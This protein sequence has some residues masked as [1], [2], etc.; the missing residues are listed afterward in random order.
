MKAKWFLLFFVLSIGAVHGQ[1]NRLAKNSLSIGLEPSISTSGS[2]PTSF[3]YWAA[4]LVLRLNHQA[5]LTNWF[6]LRSEILGAMYLPEKTYFQNDRIDNQGEEVTDVSVA[7]SASRRAA[8]S[9]QP[10]FY[11][12][13]EK[14]SLFAGVGLNL[15]IAVQRRR[16]DDAFS[17][18][19][20]E[21]PIKFRESETFSQSLFATALE[22][23]AG[24]AFNMGR[25]KQSE[26]ELAMT[27]GFWFYQFFESGPRLA[28]SWGMRVAY[29][30]NFKN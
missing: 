12:R 24:I 10:L 18:E 11:Y 23:V 4:G 16:Q 29:R 14:F 25:D 7:Y 3:S 15:G 26:L 1:S 2:P 20:Q 27:R 21:P 13:D 8:F 9:L 30:Y 5:N 6:S 28:N 22:P 19:Q 17:V